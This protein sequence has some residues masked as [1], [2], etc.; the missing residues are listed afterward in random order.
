MPN[1][2]PDRL[3]VALQVMQ[4]FRDS[5][6]PYSPQ[7]IERAT[8]E[9]LHTIR[10][11]H[12]ANMPRGMAMYEYE[13]KESSA[14]FLK[15]MVHTASTMGHN[16]VAG[17]VGSALS[18]SDSDWA[19]KAS[20]DMRSWAHE[21][22]AENV[23]RD[24]ELQ[25]YYAWKEDEPSWSG[26]D[27]TMRAMS[28]VIPSLAASISGT[29]LGV[30]AAPLTGG[31]S[32]AT[33]VVS[34]TPMFLLENSSHYIEQMDLMV[35][36]MGMSPEE[37]NEYAGMSALTY[38]I[39]AAMLERVGARAMMKGVPGLDQ[40]VPEKAM[41]RKITES[42]IES[43]A[44]KSALGNMGMR[45]LARLTNVIEKAMIEGGTEWSQAMAEAV[46]MYATEH[47]FKD[48]AD[49][50][51]VLGEEM[52][53]EG[54]LEQAFGGGVMGVP[55]GMFLPGG[56][57]AISARQ[58]KNIMDRVKEK[59]KAGGFDEVVEEGTPDYLNN[60]LAA[61]VNPRERMGSFLEDF[62]ASDDK[63]SQAIDKV[64]GDTSYSSAILRLI[65]EDPTVVAAIENHP[66]RDR[67]LKLASQKL[68]KQKPQERQIDVENTDEMINAVKMFA[69][70]GNITQADKPADLTQSEEEP[71]IDWSGDL[72]DQ[73]PNESLFYPQVDEEI[74]VEEEPPDI[75]PTEE[76][77]SRG[78][79][80]FGGFQQKKVETQ[81]ER[82]VNVG[83]TGV[84]E[85]GVYKGK[86]VSIL[87]A[88][89]KMYKVQ[90]L[91]DAGQTT[92]PQI[93][94][95][96]NQINIG[97]EAQAQE[98]VEPKKIT[99]KVMKDFISTGV[100]PPGILQHI[101]NKIADNKKLTKNEEAIR[102]DKSAEIESLLKKE[103]APEKTEEVS[104]ELTKE[105]LLGKEEAVEPETQQ[106]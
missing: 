60:Y 79:K 11:Q 66:D 4:R 58:S 44:K 59:S 88:A 74:D 99:A 72:I 31:S 10:Q 18:M 9:T 57:K 53:S 95:Y 97:E 104:D 105:D 54:V 38:G 34:L 55:F 83:K 69:E 101:A 52:F 73:T 25:A 87:A 78:Q 106:N 71:S 63:I 14:G 6:Q 93:Y 70:K 22:V 75:E 17:S 21:K 41:M 13:G 77:I 56:S 28:E 35:D 27:T 98:V 92:G 81:E 33:A 42:L 67:L 15:R 100:V 26:F 90:E 47:D 91:D 89:A 50:F 49:F 3:T 76:E 16:L 23:A 24:P 48:S 36:E 86:K 45:G 62:E 12:F 37:A 20:E 29:V 46:S 61:I 40:F 96:P 103:V 43:G 1:E 80:I 65:K 30:A 85:T 51:N 68:N 82:K 32:L 94:V 64:K 2:L 102:S 19:V 8:E 7:D 84:V 39:F 5:G